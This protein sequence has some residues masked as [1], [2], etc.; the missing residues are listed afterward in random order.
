[1]KQMD[2]SRPVEEYAVHELVNILIQRGINSNGFSFVSRSQ[3]ETLVALW[4]EDQ[5]PA[6]WPF[7]SSQP[8][9]NNPF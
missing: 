8:V 7:P 1:M 2:E 5:T 6:P 3:M 4:R 9:I